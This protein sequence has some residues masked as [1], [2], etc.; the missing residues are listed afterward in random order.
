MFAGVIGASLAV[1]GLAVAGSAGSAAA[2]VPAAVSPA[3]AT[4]TATV[5]ASLAPFTRHTQVIGQVAA[6]RRQ[7]IQVWLQP[8]T[9]AATAFAQV[10]STR[11]SSQFH[12]YL[13]PDAYAARFAATPAAARAV[14][15]WLHTQ[16]FT[17]I[18]TN[19]QRSYVAATAT[20]SVINRAFDVRLTLYK[21]PAGVN[22]GAQPV[23]SNDRP[24]S[25]PAGLASTVLGVTGLDNVAPV[26]TTRTQTPGSAAAS[27]AAC[28]AYYGQHLQGGLPVHFGR[29]SF[30]TQICGY[31]A[32]QLRAAYGASTASTGKGVTIAFTEM[33]PVDPSV[34]PALQDYSRVMGLPVPSKKQYS[35]RSAGKGCTAAA[36]GAAEQSS[37]GVNPDIEEQMDV[38]AAHALA[39]G[40]NELVV[41]GLACGGTD[42][43]TQ[44]LLNAVQAILNGSGHHPLASIV[45]NSWETDPEGQPASVTKIEHADLLQAAAE[46]VGMYVAAGDAPGLEA[47]SDD[48]YA[49]A[50]GGTTLGIGRTG[51]RLF[52]TGWSTGELQLRQGKWSDQGEYSA[53]GGGP[54]AVWGE[55]QYQRGVVPAVLSRIP[56]RSGQ[57]RSVPDISASGDPAAAM[58]VGMLSTQPGTKGRFYLT[59]G[60]GTSEATPLVAAMVAVA[61]QG[62]KKPFGFLNPVLY[63]LAGTSALHDA[64]PLTASSPSL[65]RG[66]SCGAARCGSRMLNV[67]DDQS[68]AKAD[69]FA[70]QVTLKGYDNMSGLGTPAGQHFIAAL[71][72]A[73]PR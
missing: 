64:L 31:S 6:S 59:S 26:S 45:S 11:G 14:E 41:A 17:A 9:V 27:T 30:P 56:G 18:S 19:P 21:S 40:A 46:G 58:A 63:K 2:T 71:R 66:A 38:E 32:R 43:L 4:A 8:R 1:A 68:T 16:G 20:T 52:E 12:H 3:T 5:A 67:F 72:K 22:A 73:E 7:T 36:S 33:G 44:G 23:W 70:G 51:N 53:S 49:I 13:S 24:I 55:P 47:P 48:P 61:Q 60:G 28:S 65:F 35:A 34:L 37:A 15:S 57:F 29:T 69:R 54:S 62:M 39:P 25:L 42:P 50:V 10:V